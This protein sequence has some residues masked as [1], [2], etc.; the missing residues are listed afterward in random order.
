[1][2]HL[3]PPAIKILYK[4]FFNKRIYQYKLVSA[5]DGGA[6]VYRAVLSPELL[7]F[8]LPVEKAISLRFVRW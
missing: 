8:E 7:C 6:V 3:A 2:N 4:A 5:G 1:M